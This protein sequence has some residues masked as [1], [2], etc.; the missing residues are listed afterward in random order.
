MLMQDRRNPEP[1]TGTMNVRLTYATAQVLFALADGL[2]YGFDIADA[3][4]LRGGTV[5]PILRRLE[6]AGLVASKWE[7]P[8]ISRDAG[9]PPRKYY[10]LLYTAMPV[11]EASR[12]RFPDARQSGDRSRESGVARTAGGP[13]RVESR[14]AVGAAGLEEAS[15]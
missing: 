9:R 7:A 4:G 14:G 5:Y 2:R 13:G 10:R 1:G 12:S 3:T 11:L 8:E 6:G 15:W